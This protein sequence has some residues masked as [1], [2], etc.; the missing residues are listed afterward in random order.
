MP[1]FY[2]HACWSE[3]GIRFLPELESHML[4]SASPLQDKYSKLPSLL[5]SPEKLKKLAF[6]CLS[7]CLSPVLSLF[8][9]VC[10][11][12]LTQPPH[13]PICV[14]CVCTHKLL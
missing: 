7:V 1:V 14:C 6:V 10:L 5:F 11:C 4:V 9:C 8:L 12:V 2:L 13:T 3:E